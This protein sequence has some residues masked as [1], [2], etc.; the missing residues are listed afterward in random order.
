MTRVASLTARPLDAAM[1]EP[2][3]IAGGSTAAVRN[4]LVTVRLTDGAVG[5]GEAAPFAAFN[6]EGTSLLS[7]VSYATSSP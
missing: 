5:Y 6:G 7:G 4:V 2:F 3:E 1:S